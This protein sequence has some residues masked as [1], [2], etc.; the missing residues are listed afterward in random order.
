MLCVLV[1]VHASNAVCMVA[2]AAPP[3]C[4]RLWGTGH[5]SP[6]ANRRAGPDA[7]PSD[8]ATS[9]AHTTYPA[10]Q[11]LL[12]LN[13]RG[14]ALSA[15]PHRAAHH[16]DPRRYGSPTLCDHAD[17]DTDLYPGACRLCDRRCQQVRCAQAC[18]DPRLY[19]TVLA[20]V[21]L[22]RLDSA[23]GNGCGRLRALRGVRSSRQ[24]P[25]FLCAACQPS[26]L[27]LRP[28]L[29]NSMLGKVYRELM[30]LGFISF[31]VVISNVRV[32]IVAK[33]VLPIC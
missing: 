31:T 15:P 4:G 26:V 16:G 33:H 17:L 1:L 2:S 24:P 18:T 5:G 11:K 22:G 10:G 27:T 25:R 12:Q 6:A 13:S 30:I 8:N 20:C 9:A 29:R 19:A 14:Y 7:T 28:L 32:T 3:A 21:G 23:A